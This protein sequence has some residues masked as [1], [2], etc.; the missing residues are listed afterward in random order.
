MND[1]SGGVSKE[2]TG[3]DGDNDVEADK[4]DEDSKITP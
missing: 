4:G 2:S 3:N 1:L